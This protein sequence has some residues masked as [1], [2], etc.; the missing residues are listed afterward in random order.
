VLRYMTHNDANFGYAVAIG[1][2][3]AYAVKG[4]PFVALVGADGSLLWQGPGGSF[5]G[6]HIE[7]ALKAVKKPTPEQQEAKAAKS[8]AYAEKLIEDKR[9]VQAEQVL[10]KAAARFG[11]TES[12]KKAAERAKEIAAS[13]ELKAEFAAQKE[14]A[15]LL[16]GVE[17]PAEADGKKA[18]KLV[19]VLEKKAAEWQS[20]APRAAALAE[21]WKKICADPWK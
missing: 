14:L 6:K 21:E 18:E 10:Q 2:A 17:K 9:L 5:S 13:E 7:E 16:G 20:S 8:L 11:A 15:K 12:G 4:I 1:Q 19:K 3:P